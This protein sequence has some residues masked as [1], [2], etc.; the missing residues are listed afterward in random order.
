MIT[1]NTLAAFAQEVARNRPVQGEATV[2]QAQAR[3]PAQEAAPAQRTLEAIP[4]LPPRPLPRGSLL[5][6]RA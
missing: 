3:R 2:Q 4:P 1:L 6:I 5:D